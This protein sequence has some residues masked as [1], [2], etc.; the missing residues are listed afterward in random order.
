MAKVV[1]NTGGSEHAV[2]IPKDIA[3][4]PDLFL[5]GGH[6]V[7]G[8]SFSRHFVAKAAGDDGCSG[9]CG[10]EFHLS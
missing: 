4:V 2:L 5:V 8:L 6:V 7:T 9:D 1:V 10:K 3:V